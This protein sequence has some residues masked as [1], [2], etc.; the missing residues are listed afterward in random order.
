VDGRSHRPEEGRPLVSLIIPT[1]NDAANLARTLPIL[2]SEFGHSPEVELIVVDDGSRDHSA[3]LIKAHL[4]GFGGARL[5]ELPWNQGKGSAVKA[6]VNA[7]RGERFVFMDAD[8]SADIADLPRLLAALNNADVAV[9]SRSIAGSR[10]EYQ[11]PMRQFQSKFFNSVACVLTQVVASDTQC[12]F[13]AFRTEPG[14]LLFHLTEGKG[15]AFDVEVLALAQLLD[16]R[17]VEVP[18]HWVDVSGTSVRTVRDP[19]LMIRDILRTRRRCK[20]LERR[21][22]RRV[23]EAVRPAQD[24]DAQLRELLAASDAY[25]ERG[26]PVLDV[27]SDEGH[28]AGGRRS[29][30]G[31]A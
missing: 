14:K 15:F 8:L 20:N 31:L 26:H 6:G 9:G 3:E 17:I 23:D 19:F 12:G 4:R 24:L 28:E 5:I 22:G 13:K 2:R 10:V 25:V 27:V 18:I 7:V 29:T 30:S 16:M 11:Q 1:Y 21:L